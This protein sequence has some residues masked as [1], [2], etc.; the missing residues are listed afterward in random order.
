MRL[1]ILLVDDEELALRNLARAVMKAVPD[2]ELLTAQDALTALGIL[3]SFRVDVIFADMEMPGM[4]GIKFADEARKLREDYNIIFT[5][6]YSEY[7]LEAIRR[8]ASGYLLKPVRVEDIQRELEH[9]RYPLAGEAEK[10]LRA[11]CFG[12][13]EVYHHDTVIHFPRKAEREILAWLV[14]LRGGGSNTEELCRILWEDPAERARRRDYLRVLYNSLRK[15]LDTFGC[16]DALVKHPNYFAIDPTMID[17]DYYNM[18]QGK[19][20]AINAW[21][22]EYMSQYAWAQHTVEELNALAEEYASGRRTAK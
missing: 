10:P 5:T 14:D 13:F 20:D 4:N 17:C 16:A 21:H 11:V 22:G 2:C 7:A 1:H 9:L 19:A 3:E 6:A 18:L 15:T 12:R 8:R